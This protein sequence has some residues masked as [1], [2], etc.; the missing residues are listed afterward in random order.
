MADSID[1]IGVI[2]AQVHDLIAK[3][4]LAVGEL[5]QQAQVVAEQDRRVRELQSQLKNLRSENEELRLLLSFNGDAAARAKLAKQLQA[6][7]R[8]LNQVLQKIQP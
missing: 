8:E 2:Q 1:R 6:W 5:E 4:R 7:S 3:Y